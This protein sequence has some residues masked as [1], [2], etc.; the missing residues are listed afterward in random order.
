MYTDEVQDGVTNPSPIDGNG[1][2][3]QDAADDGGYSGYGRRTNTG[4]ARFH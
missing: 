4:P 3:A 1:L 2:Q